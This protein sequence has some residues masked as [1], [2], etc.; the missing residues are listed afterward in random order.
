MKACEG[1]N[2]FSCSYLGSLWAKD[3]DKARFGQELLKRGC[4]EG[5]DFGCEQLKPED[6]S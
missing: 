3:P 1:G 5:D 2:A 6:P 4:D